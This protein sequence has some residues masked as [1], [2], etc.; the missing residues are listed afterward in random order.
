MKNIRTIMLAL[1]A[2]AL[3]APTFNA[4]TDEHEQYEIN[5]PDWIS[6]VADSIAASKANS[7]N[8]EADPIWGS[9]LEDVYTVG[10]TDYSSG[11][12]T[13]FSKNYVIP[14]DSVWRAQFDLH[15]NPDDNTYYKNVLL[16]LATDARGGDKYKEYGVWRYDYTADSA[17][18]NSQWGD[19]MWFK[20]STADFEMAPDGDSKDALLQDMNGTVNLSVA[21]TEGKIDIIMTNGTLTKEYHGPL[22]DPSAI[23]DQDDGCIRAFLLVEGAY[24][25]FLGTN[26]TP[27]E[28]LTSREDKKPLSMTLNGVPSAIPFSDTLNL[29]SIVANITADIAFEE[30]VTATVDASELAFTIVPDLT[31]IGSK[32][33]AVAY[34]KTF[35]GESADPVM[36][37]ASFKVVEFSAINIDPITYYVNGDD[38]YSMPTAADLLPI[39][40]AV[41][42]EG[43]VFDDDLKSGIVLDAFTVRRAGKRTITG[44]WNGLALSFELNVVET[45]QI[46]GLWKGET[47]GADDMSTGFWSAFPSADV[48]IANGK[49]VV[50]KYSQK[51]DGL[52][53]WHGAV[54]ILR[55]QALTPEYAVCRADNH[56]WADYFPNTDEYKQCNW[57]F[58]TFKTETSDCE[59]TVYVTNNNGIL[60]IYLET[61]ANGKSYYQRYSTLKVPNADDVYFSITL[62]N[63]QLVFK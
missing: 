12:W 25:D 50:A 53:N 39:I 29:E 31:T 20:Y 63:A 17:A 22:A 13:L 48:K 54:F 8:S 36:A 42:N 45:E 38:P 27:I 55:A 18:Y 9:L 59:N 24:F 51:S 1:G 58:D 26:I 21:Y 16:V 6:S 35:K 49:T 14:K 44:N 56:G 52:E 46:T 57:N 28:G 23:S 34:A 5:A 30:G 7:G 11:F 19:Y 47:I 3:L 37:V 60:S 40:N 43:T 32:T 61:V 62:E 2:A 41:G 4:C 15:I 33:L 10:N